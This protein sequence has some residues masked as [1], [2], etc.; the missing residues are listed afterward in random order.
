MQRRTHFLKNFLKNYES[1]VTLWAHFSF[2]MLLNINVKT[3]NTTTMFRV[4]WSLSSVG[5]TAERDKTLL[6]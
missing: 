5:A 3:T 4:S 1:S 6:S 2:S